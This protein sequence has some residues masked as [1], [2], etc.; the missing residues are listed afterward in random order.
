MPLGTWELT[1]DYNSGGKSESGD[2]IF[3]LSAIARPLRKINIALA[4]LKIQI[5]FWKF[6]TND[7]VTVD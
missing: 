4:V 2:M 3:V 5:Q 1:S 7:I 6:I